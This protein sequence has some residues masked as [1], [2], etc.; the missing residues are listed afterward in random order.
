[1]ILGSGTVETQ[2]DFYKSRQHY[3]FPYKQPATVSRSYQ[4][5]AGLSSWQTRTKSSLGDESQ[6]TASFTTEMPLPTEQTPAR[7]NISNIVRSAFIGG[8]KGTMSS[9][10]TVNSRWIDSSSS[11]N[12]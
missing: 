10:K 4:T 5:M 3:G 9:F 7:N 2:L 6:K 1:M 12:Y 11:R 8:G